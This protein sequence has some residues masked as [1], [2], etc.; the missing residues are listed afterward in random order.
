[1]LVC[2]FIS[3]TTTT[4]TLSV[5]NSRFND[6]T[7]NQG[8]YISSFSSG[9]VNASFDR[10]EFSNNHLEGLDVQTGGG[11]IIIAVTDCVAA[12]NGD[13]AFRINS[14]NVG[15]INLSLTHCLIA[16]N[17]V[18]VQAAKVNATIWLAQSTLTGNA[19]GYMAAI[20]GV[21]NSFADNYFVANGPN[22]GLLGSAT[23]Q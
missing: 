4:E 11:T 8:V 5:S 1:M 18:G 15:A 6:N 14:G 21:V 9:A 16:N 2:F 7:G 3:N 12:S 23:R 22:T 19:A 20:G 17:S 13:I 10:A